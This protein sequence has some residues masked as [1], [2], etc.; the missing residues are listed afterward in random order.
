MLPKGRISHTNAISS[1]AAT[2]GTEREEREI[3][4]DG[5]EERRGDNIV[6]LV[7]RTAL[8]LNRRC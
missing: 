6:A 4:S 2:W 7:T 1:N 8:S 5:G 3:E